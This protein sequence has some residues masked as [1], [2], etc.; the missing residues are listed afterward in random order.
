MTVIP[1]KKTGI[2]YKNDTKCLKN[3]VKTAKKPIL[4]E[5]CAAVSPI[6]SPKR[7]MNPKSLENL[8]RYE[9]GDILARLNG[10]KGSDTK[11]LKAAM[12][13]DNAK[14]AAEG[15]RIPQLIR[16]ALAIADKKPQEALLKLTIA[17]KAAKISGALPEQSPDAKQKFE[18]SGKLDNKLE[19]EI[20]G[21]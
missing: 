9:A 21:V 6:A 8:T 10:K 3:A 16:D 1:A 19:V 14:A 7:E 4:R 18:L 17:E 5:K 11:A 2:K 15:N 12:L 13:N 20:K